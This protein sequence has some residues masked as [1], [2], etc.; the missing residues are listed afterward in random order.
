MAENIEEYSHTKKLFLPL[1]SSCVICLNILQDPHIICEEGHNLCKKCI[2][3]MD[4]SIFMTNHSLFISNHIKRECPVCKTV[5]LNKPVKNIL[6]SNIFIDI[7]NKLSTFIKYKKGDRVDVS[8]EYFFN[9]DNE[10][11]QYIETEIIDVNYV[12][13]YFSIR[14]YCV[15]NESIGWTRNIPFHE[16]KTCMFPH[17][18]KIINW[19]TLDYL[20]KNKNIRVYWGDKWMT[21]VILWHDSIL[22]E[23]NVLTDY[24]LVGVLNEKEPKDTAWFSVDHHDILYHDFPI[25]PFLSKYNN[26]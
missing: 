15:R 23:M 22:N 10:L 12:N 3:S 14:P 19:R 26:K 25:N 20:E 2:K 17:F 7:E 6:L 16:Y 5:L 13:E 18:E 1:L 21:G 8:Q 11:P 9:V 24:V 4:N